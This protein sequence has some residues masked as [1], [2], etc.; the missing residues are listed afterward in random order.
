MT[1]RDSLFA[2]NTNMNK[3]IDCNKRKLGVQCYKLI[4]NVI[5]RVFNATQS[6]YERAID[7]SKDCNRYHACVNKFCVVRTSTLTSDQI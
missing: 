4:I 5:K 7:N 1:N 3:E 6:V 2:V